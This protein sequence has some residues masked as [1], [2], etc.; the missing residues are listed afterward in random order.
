MYKGKTEPRRT[1]T[2][3]FHKSQLQE[4]FGHLYAK[5]GFTIQEGV[6]YRDVNTVCREPDSLDG[7]CKDCFKFI[8][9]GSMGFV[10]MTSPKYYNR[11]EVSL[12]ECV[13]DTAAL[14]AEA[15]ALPYDRTRPDTSI[16]CMRN[17]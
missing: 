17:E 2:Y 13:G 14:R 5:L 3:V 10:G 8:Y 1:D 4:D 6:V 11:K 7:T 12:E 9:G 16:W 15:D